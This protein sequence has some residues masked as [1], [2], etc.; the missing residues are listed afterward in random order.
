MVPS[1]ISQGRSVTC[2]SAKAPVGSG[3]LATFTQ[4]VG[5]LFQS[6]PCLHL[7]CDLVYPQNIC[8]QVWEFFLKHFILP[9]YGLEFSLMPPS[10]HQASQVKGS[11][12]TR[13]PIF[14]ANWLYVGVLMTLGFSN[15]L[16]WLTELREIISLLLPV[17]LIKKGCNSGCSQMDE[18]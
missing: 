2:P 12:S 11:V 15:L 7:A 1:G 4:L 8:H 13:P 16:E 17:F 5:P 3:N 10:W 18:A 14:L 6:V 9:I